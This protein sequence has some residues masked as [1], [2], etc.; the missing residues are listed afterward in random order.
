[1]KIDVP[2]DVLAGT[3]FD[4]DHALLDL[5]LGMYADSRASLGQAARISGMHQAAFMKELSSRRIPLHYDID[6]FQQD[7]ATLDKL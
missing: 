6:D 3:S 4:P 1:M 5:A 7:M 2:D